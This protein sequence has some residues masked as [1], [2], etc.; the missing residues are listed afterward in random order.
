[1]TAAKTQ[2]TRRAVIATENVRLDQPSQDV[3]HSLVK[4]TG[5]ALPDARGVEGEPPT[6]NVVQ[7]LRDESFM[8]DTIEVT[9]AEPGNEWEPQYV[10]VGV[11]GEKFC[12]RRGD[13]VSIKRCH[14]AVVAAAKQ[15]RV[16]QDKITLPDGSMGYRELSVLQPVYPFQ[17]LSDPAGQ[18]GLTWLRQIMQRS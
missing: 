2:Y 8:R 16:K 13:T 6:G 11:N 10:E 14:L 5:I 7:A 1:M 17:V 4:T 9:F 15:T 12:A 18:S 3:D